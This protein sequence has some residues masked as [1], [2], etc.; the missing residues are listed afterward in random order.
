MT[1]K[2]IFSNGTT[3]TNEKAR[4]ALP[5]LLSLAKSA[6][7]ITYRN[8]DNEIA[9]QNKEPPTPIVVGY[10]KVLEIVGQALN[11]LSQEWEEEIPPL[12]ILVVNGDN[13]KP[14]YGVDGFLK[15]YVTKNIAKNL[16]P[17]NRSAMI[18]RATNAVYNYACWDDV[19]SYFEIDI[20]GSLSEAKPIQLP[21]PGLILGGESKAHLALKNHVAEHPELFSSFG[22]FKNGIIE[23][24][25]DSGDEVDILFQNNEQ[26]LAVEIKT[27]V[28]SQSELARGI[29]Q[30]VKYRAVLR[31][32]YDIEGKL[33]NVQTVLVTPQQLSAVHKN[34]ARRLNVNSLRINTVAK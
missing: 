17:N 10:G 28:A 4:S 9:K 7:K 15:R 23:F 31:A 11:Q 30:C 8:L 14:S 1:A 16:T 19:A 34:A 33:I 27:D 25:L 18:E 21:K 32:M 20:S 13:G 3:W 24:R 26:T 5:I 6:S 22:D 12:T 29:F 2:D